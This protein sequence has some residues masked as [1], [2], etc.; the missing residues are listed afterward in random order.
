M[1]SDMR[2]LHQCR[3]KWCISTFCDFTPSAILKLQP[4]FVIMFTL[5]VY[6]SHDVFWLLTMLQQYEHTHKTIV[7]LTTPYLLLA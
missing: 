5:A 3:P 7:H 1:P 6:V 2:T 4:G